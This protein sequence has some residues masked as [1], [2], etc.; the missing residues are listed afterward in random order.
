MRIGG[1][2]GF[3]VAALL[4]SATE[5]AAAGAAAWDV[6][7]ESGACSAD[8]P[9]DRDATLSVVAFGPQV[10]VV[11]AANDFPQGKGTTPLMLRFDGGAAQT[12]NA[13]V[14]GRTYGIA[15][16][17]QLY[18]ALREGARLDVSSSGQTA[19]GFA[20]DGIAQAIDGVLSCTGQGSY[21]AVLSHAPQ[22]IPGI[23]WMISDPMAGTNECAVRRNGRDVD[24][25][26]SLN[27]SGA[28]ILTAGRPDWAMPPTSVQATLAIGDA[29]PVAVQAIVFTNVVIVNLDK[30]DPALPAALAR[31]K[32][33]KWSFSWGQF[34][35]DIAGVDKALDA[36][37]AC[38][39]KRP[40]AP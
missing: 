25:T 19:Y 17:Q 12:L 13:E 15:L 33:L 29:Q 23:D 28:V 1:L 30:N 16:T 32:S 26:I 36:L 3:V 14:H 6:K 35:A 27:A 21:A 39:A 11:I 9:S 34:E 2:A 24:T 8:G 7:H 37:R 40:G 20:L 10:F 4:L 18:R 22:P 38:Q 5:P 31:A